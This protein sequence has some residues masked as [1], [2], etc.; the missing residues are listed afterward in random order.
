[1]YAPTQID[2]MSFGDWSELFPDRPLLRTNYLTA[3]F[4][5]EEIKKATFQLAENKAQ[6]PN[7]FN[8]RFFQF[9]W[10]TVNDNLFNIFQDLADGM[11]NSSPLDYSYVC[12]IEEK[13]GAKS[14]NDFRPISLIN[15]A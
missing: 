7:G 14:A 4:S 3:P 10:D 12:L 8:I 9:F 15:G 6:G 1:M 13:E 5:L 2:R 11:L